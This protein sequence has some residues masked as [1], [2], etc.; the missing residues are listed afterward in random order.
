MKGHVASGNLDRYG[1]PSGLDL[2]CLSASTLG[3]IAAARAT[4][5]TGTDGITSDLKPRRRICDNTPTSRVD[6]MVSHEFLRDQY[7]DC[8]YSR[9]RN[10]RM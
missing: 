6:D 3:G 7:A 10:P 8:Q 4:R 1:M 2:L 9:G 5:L